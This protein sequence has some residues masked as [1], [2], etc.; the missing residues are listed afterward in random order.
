MFVLSS[1]DRTHGSE[2]SDSIDDSE[3]PLLGGNVADRVVRVGMTVRKPATSATPAVEAFLEHLHN[4]GF[5]GAPRTFGRDKQGRQILEYIPGSTVDISQPLSVVDLQKIGRLI[6]ELHVAA[7][8]FVPPAS[9]HWNVAIRPDV[10]SQICHHDLAPW[11]LVTDGERWVFIDWDGCGPGSPMWDLAYAAQSF[12]PL[13]SSGIPEEDASRLRVFVDAYG[14]D[15]TQREEFP[16]L[17]F[18]R[19][20]AMYRLLTDAAVT[21]HQPWARLHADG[22]H[23]HWGS[24]ADYIEQHQDLWTQALQCREPQG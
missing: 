20:R 12:I 8:S 9:A 5:M 11:N 7:Q 4:Q 21:G 16:G 18:H 3:Q 17:L 6:R 15:R 1:S 24:S 19:T 2:L 14:L 22:H 13:L 10:E 23:R